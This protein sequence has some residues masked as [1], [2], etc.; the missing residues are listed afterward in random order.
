MDKAMD[1]GDDAI[2]VMIDRGHMIGIVEPDE[3]R[4]ARAD[5]ADDG[6]PVA[7]RHYMI[8]ARL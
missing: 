8:V 2:L 3:L 5:E 1:L 4:A 6:F 7:R